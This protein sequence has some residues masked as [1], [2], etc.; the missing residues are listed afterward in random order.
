ME[1]NIDF[2]LIFFSACFTVIGLIAIT[3]LAGK[4][5]AGYFKK[6]LWFLGILPFLLILFGLVS[7]VYSA[8]DT[9][10]TATTTAVK[11][12]VVLLP[13]FIISGYIGN[14]VGGVF[15]WIYRMFKKVRKMLG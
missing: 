5:S 3:E 10:G 8:P 9:T 13:S 7:D 6:F 2:R 11:Q 14:A 12:A 4:K 15:W 1:F